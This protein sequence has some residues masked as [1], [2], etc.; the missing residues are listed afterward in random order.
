MTTDEQE[1]LL[2]IVKKAILTFNEKEKYLLKNNLSER[3][4]CSKFAD[5]LNREL[6]VNEKYIQYDVDVEY[7]RGFDGKDNKPK[8]I[9]GK[10]AVVDLIV[11]KRGYD[12]FYGYDNLICIEMKK[13][14]DSRGKQG[15]IDDQ[16]RLKDLAGYEYGFCYKLG[17]MLV[18]NVKK[19]L[20]EILEPVYK[21]D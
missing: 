7:N 13:T 8:K 19:Q 15:I 17:I 12:E 10:N 4:I 3:C 5:Y 9:Y 21:L 11:H 18:A 1:E 14:N 2:K 20:L 16:A 6:K